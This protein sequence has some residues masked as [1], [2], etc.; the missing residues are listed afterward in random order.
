MHKF[1]IVYLFDFQ[2]EEKLK[3]YNKTNFDKYYLINHK[4]LIGMGI[5]INYK[6]IK[7]DIEKN[8]IDLNII[9]NDNNNIKNI[10]FFKK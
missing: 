10:Y 3:K 7:K 5:N 4:S 8:N 1:I 9:C 6:L 2:I